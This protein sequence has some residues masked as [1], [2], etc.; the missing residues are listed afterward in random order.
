MKPL[1]A[2]V[3]L[4]CVGA[5]SG[6]G[7]LSSTS[8]PARATTQPGVL[9]VVKLVITDD[10]IVVRGDKFM[11]RTGIPHYPRGSDVRYDVRNRATRPFRLNILGSS[12]GM[13]APG[14]QSSILVYWSRRGKF[15]F[16]ALPNGPTIHIWVV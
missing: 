5:A 14:R 6:V 1:R 15:V 16:R 7:I 11:T 13:L 9:S 12:T 2:S 4:V 3:S 8:H 10:K